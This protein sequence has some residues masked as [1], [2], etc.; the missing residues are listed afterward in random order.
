[1]PKGYEPAGLTMA[2]VMR[3]MSELEKEHPCFVTM[4]QYISHKKETDGKLII[5]VA[6]H[7]RTMD[8]KGEVVYTA[9]MPWPTN[10][11][12]TVLGAMYW[13]LIDVGSQL[14]AGDVLEHLGA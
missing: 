3:V 8:N 6:A 7:R 12:K 13:L 14:A 10:S 1:M 9:S 11:H 4:E 5:S 2:E